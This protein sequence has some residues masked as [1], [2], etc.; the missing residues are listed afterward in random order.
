V[1]TPVGNDRKVV[2]THFWDYPWI[3]KKSFRW[4][5]HFTANKVRMFYKNRN[6]GRLLEVNCFYLNFKEFYG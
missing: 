3:S 4:S 1:K 6:L 2:I 5:I